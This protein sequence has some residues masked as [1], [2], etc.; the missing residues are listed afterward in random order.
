M[1]RLYQIGRLGV[2]GHGGLYRVGA[3]GG[4]NTGGHALGSFNRY[5]KGGGELLGVA[6]DHLRN[7]QLAATGFGQGQANQAPAVFGHEI[8]VFRAHMLGG[9]DQITFVFPVF[10]IHQDD[11]FTLTDIVDDFLGTA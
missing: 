9:H 8:D 10:I 6:A 7:I 3:I 5:G 2:L 4:R 11:H 1:P